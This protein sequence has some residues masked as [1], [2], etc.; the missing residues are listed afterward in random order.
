MRIKILSYSKKSECFKG[1]D[2]SQNK[3]YKIYCMN[4]KTLL[5]KANRKNLDKSKEKDNLFL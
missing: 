4:F 1:K 5:K 3:I 2:F